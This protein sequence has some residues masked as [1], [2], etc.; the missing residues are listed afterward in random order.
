LCISLWDDANGFWPVKACEQ[1][2]NIHKMPLSHRNS[3]CEESEV[4]YS[5]FK[6]Y[7]IVVPYTVGY[8]DFV[9]FDKMEPPRPEIDLKWDSRTHL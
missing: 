3:L 5:N 9:F 2:K 6:L 7:P 8:N 1:R 4:Q